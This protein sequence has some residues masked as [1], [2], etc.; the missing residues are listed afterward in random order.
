MEQKKKELVM[1]NL[2]RSNSA[3]ILST[4]DTKNNYFIMDYFDWIK[5]EHLNWDQAH[6]AD[7]MGIGEQGNK[8]K[9]GISHQRYCLYSEDQ[10]R[11]FD[12]EGC[13][14]LLTI[15]QVFINPDLYQCEKFTDGREISRQVCMEKV[16]KQIEDYQKQTKNFVFGL[17]SLLT[18]GDFAVV[19]RSSDIHVAY[20][21][22]SL[23]RSIKI[24][25]K[26]VGSKA[27]GEGVFY[28]Y[29]ISGSNIEGEVEEIGDAWSEYLSKDD[30]V[31]IRVC[32]SQTFRQNNDGKSEREKLLDFGER[33]L[34]RYDYQMECD[35]EEF[36]EMYPFLLKFKSGSSVKE[37][38]AEGLKTEKAK[39][40]LWLMKMGYI[41]RVNEKL[42]LKYQSDEFAE[43][44]YMVEWEVDDS[45]IDEWETLYEKNHTGIQL[46]KREEKD[47]EEEIEKYYM[48]ERNLKE[49]VRLL[50]RFCRVFYEI[51]K[52]PELRISLAVLIKQFDVFLM[53]IKNCLISLKVFD[54][55]RE[56]VADLA[57]N[58]EMGIRTLEIYTRYIRNINLQT[59]QT[60][61]YDLQT[62]VCVE[63]VLLAYSR[64]LVPFM[65]YRAKEEY[66][67]LS[68]TLCP[69][70]VPVMGIADLSVAVIFD[71]DHQEYDKPKLMTVSSPTFRNLCET[72]FLIP[73]IFHEIAHQ[74]RYEERENRN[75]C[76][77]SYIL[78]SLIFNIVG[79]FLGLKADYNIEQDKM[80]RNCVTEIYDLMVEKS[81]GLSVGTGQYLNLEG[82]REW[83]REKIL[84]YIWLVRNRNGILDKLVINYVGKV[85]TSICYYDD[86]MV[87]AIKNLLSK[88]EEWKAAL[89]EE[90]EKK[91]QDINTL[92]MLL[93]REQTTQ[94]FQE[95]GIV[96]ARAKVGCA[97]R[98][99]EQ[100]TR[101]KEAEAKG[102]ICDAERKKLFDEWNN[103]RRNKEWEVIGRKQDRE[104]LENLMKKYHNQVINYRDIK[105]RLEDSI[106]DGNPKK[107]YD[108]RN[109]VEQLN[110]QIYDTI[111]KNVETA[112]IERNQELEWQTS[113]MS[114]ETLERI[115]R[116]IKIKRPEQLEEELDEILDGL[117]GNLEYHIDA[118]IEMY[119]EVTSDLF[120]CGIIGLDAFGYL[121]VVAEY[122]EFNE[123]NEE[124][125][126]AR[127]LWVLQCIAKSD[128][129]LCDS[130]KFEACLT[131]IEERAKVAL[132]AYGQQ[133][134]AD[135]TRKWHGYIYDKICWIVSRLKG[136]QL[137]CEVLGEKEMFE[138]LTGSQSY[139]KCKGKLQEKLGDRSLKR[140]C[141]SIAEILNSP[142]KFNDQK[143]PLL[144]EEIKFIFEYYEE[145]CRSIWGGE[146]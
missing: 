125:L 62:N 31:E 65:R 61:N 50:G 75:Q 69:I 57:E 10:Q 76:L 138:D 67:Y 40:M 43:A 30:R 37:T 41:S 79:K 119:R 55:Q 51:N 127:I 97:D 136:K 38:D 64:F 95:M 141:T 60:P 145:S 140:L 111:R 137:G 17:Y 98:F 102:E 54:K 115:V 19:V 48:Y 25:G 53:S 105:Q 78:K 90:S 68:Y 144:E 39:I 8:E 134:T 106:K 18:E 107:D 23:I 36:E 116:K 89:P 22:S 131:G 52:L 94:L 42:L 26:K 124:G 142:E 132:S 12:V 129:E 6:L 7:C 63:K 35:R 15:I 16:K 118:I 74:F 2:F 101:V 84:R 73:I 49:Y 83:L 59:L 100:L 80:I 103:I 20:N 46:L 112:V 45:V 28:S 113:T 87:R 121:V 120:M 122:F 86:K 91:I 34:G 88:L 58:L 130:N 66:P 56:G 110:T 70:V 27:D 44:E 108:D 32:F 126:L 128:G 135:L 3:E 4:E 29:S 1:L 13:M 143:N 82:F 5:V 85:K 11:V 96:L 92:L 24:K 99:S 71:D 104:V 9:E 123:V 133:E 21:I 139:Y 33:L 14:P 114:T 72:C 146:K 47:I 81:E 109:K 77:Q 117:E 93:G